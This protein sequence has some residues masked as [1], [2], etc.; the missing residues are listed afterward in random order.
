MEKKQKRVL[1]GEKNGTFEHGVLFKKNISK[2]KRSLV[3]L[4][5]KQ[6]G[7]QIKLALISPTSR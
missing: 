6:S 5:L 2:L 4:F 1:E 7:S 3:L